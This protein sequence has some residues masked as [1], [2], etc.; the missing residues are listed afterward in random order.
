MMHSYEETLN[1]L[2]KFYQDSLDY[3]LTQ[4]NNEAIAE[5]K[6]LNDVGNLE[7][8]PLIPNGKKINKQAQKYF[9][10]NR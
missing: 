1:I 2:E 8:N 6:A 10:R 7:H 4:E 9:L 5:G 3:W